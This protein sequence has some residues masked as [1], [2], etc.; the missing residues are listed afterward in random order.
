LPEISVDDGQRTQL[1]ESVKKAQ[2]DLKETVWR[3]YKNVMLLG[4]DNQVRTIDLGLLHSSASE[5]LIQFIVN[6]LRQVDEIQS[7]ISPNFLVRNWSP[8]FKEWSTRAIRDAFYASPIFPRLLNGEAVKQTIARGVQDGLLA[9]VGRAKDGRYVPFM[10]ERSLDPSD[11]EISDETFIVTRDAALAYREAQAKPAVGDLPTTA[12]GHPSGTPS[13][14]E[15]GT[16]S[17]LFPEAQGK[18]SAASAGARSLRWSGEIPSQKWMNFYTRVLSR[19]ATGSGLR[20]TVRV[21]IAPNGGVSE[22][23][24]EET[25]SALR[26]L[27]LN[28]MLDKDV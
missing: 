19:F 2:R 8:A 6:Q 27:G 18:A 23:K 25:R 15:P 24:V 13:F 21:D 10:F 14:A 22:Q 11:V 1:G 5:S 4:K 26:E 12:E 17:T 20:V 9:Y 16:P 28:D 7:G 3:T